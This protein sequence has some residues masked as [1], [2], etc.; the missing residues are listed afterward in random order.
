MKPLF[1]LLCV[2]NIGFFLW[3]FHAGKLS[4]VVPAVQSGVV[5]VLT[6][7]EYRRAQRGSQIAGLI[8][9]DIQRWQQA[10]VDYMLTEL[11][12]PQKYAALENVET[13]TKPPADVKEAKA[14]ILPEPVQPVIV[15]KCFE[16]G[17]FADEA[18]AKKWL[19]QKALSSKQILLRE[20]VVSS[21]FQVYYPAAKTP[22]LSRTDKFFLKEKGLLDIWMIQDGEKKGAF[23]LGVFRDKARAALFKSQLA[24]K[25]VASE[26]RRRDQ[27]EQQWFVKL[28]L[29]KASVKQYESAAIQLSACVNNQR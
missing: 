14:E 10:D 17:P 6:V 21:D 12:G 24:A 20:K 27:T 13:S 28:A 15:R 5:K 11:S 7:D 2:L 23:S 26:I 1:F 18:S 8:Q 29:D 3:Q 22:E 16:A 25:G 4:P 9:D 19:A